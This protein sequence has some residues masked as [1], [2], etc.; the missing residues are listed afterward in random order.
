MER[1]RRVMVASLAG[2]LVLWLGCATPDGSPFAAGPN[3]GGDEEVWAIRCLTLQGPQQQRVAEDY[4]AALRSVRGL[5]RDLVQ[6]LTDEDGT[7]LFYGRYR[8]L[9]G[10]ERDEQRYRPDPRGDLELI[11]S[12]RLPDQ[13]AWPFL[14]ATMDLLPTYRSAHPEWNLEQAEGYW[15]LH[16]AVFYNTEG[17]R[18]RRSAAEEYCRMLRE[19]GESAYFH[20]GPVNSSVYIGPFPENAVMDMKT[21]NP[22]RGTVNTQRRVVDPRMLAAQQ[23]FP[24]SLHNGHRFYEIIRDAETGEVKER[25]PAPS[26]PVVVPR[27]E[28]AGAGAGR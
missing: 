18:A 13:N 1:V 14:L 24:E 6:V 3:P 7:A 12:L 8:R 23:R 26:F 28:R 22:L 9:Y 11:R 20:H 5:K 21:E 19:Q 4:A 10:P 15:A 17:M 25:L 16:V 2:G 27:A